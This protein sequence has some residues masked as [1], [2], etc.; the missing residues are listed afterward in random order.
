MPGGVGRQTVVNMRFL[1]GMFV[2]QTVLAHECVDVVGY[3]LGEMVVQERPQGGKQKK[4]QGH[5][6]QETGH[7]S[8]AG[9][10][11]RLCH[12]GGRVSFNRTGGYGHISILHRGFD[13]PSNRWG[14]SAFDLRHK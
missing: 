3:S 10:W 2:V 7:H 6:H 4:G 8:R 9:P 13:S 12:I 5:A 14:R 1:E 11:V